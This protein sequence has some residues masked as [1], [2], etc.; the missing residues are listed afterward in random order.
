MATRAS[1]DKRLFFTWTD[2]KTALLMKV[3]MDY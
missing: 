3:V 1:N 2:E